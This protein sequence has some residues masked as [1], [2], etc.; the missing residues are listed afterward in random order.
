[1]PGRLGGLRIGRLRRSKLPHRPHCRF[2]T[3][4]ECFP[5][6]R[7]DLFLQLAYSCRRHF[8]SPLRTGVA[9]ARF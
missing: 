7:L 4:G 6:D 1:M 5:T 9:F 3:G 2:E 8:L